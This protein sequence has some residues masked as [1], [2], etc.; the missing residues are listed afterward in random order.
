VVE[1]PEHPSGTETGIDAGVICFAA[2]SDGTMVKGVNGFRA[3]EERL[4]GQQKKL[5]RKK[6]GPENWEKQKRIISKFHHSIA[7]VRNDFLHK[8]RTGICKSHAKVYVE[9]LQIRNMSASARGTIEDP[10]RNVKVK[11][12]LNKSILDQGWYRFHELLR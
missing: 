9:R 1:I 12:G 3:H 6:K 7:N 10:G 2:F 5:S 11:S 8:L 4:A